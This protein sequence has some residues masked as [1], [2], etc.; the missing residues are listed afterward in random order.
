MGSGS[1]NHPVS[2]FCVCH[3]RQKMAEVTPGRGVE[4]VSR[5]HGTYHT[6][7]LSVRELLVQLSGTTNGSAIVQF[8]QEQVA[9]A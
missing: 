1:N 6:G 4:V 8:V 2:L 9:P 5:H 7:S 3:G